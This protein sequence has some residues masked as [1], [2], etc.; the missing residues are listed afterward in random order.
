MLCQWSRTRIRFPRFVVYAA[1][2]ASS[3]IA[4]GQA[5]ASPALSGPQVVPGVTGTPAQQPQN[6]QL[7]SRI[8]L[9]IGPGDE[10]DIS[11]YGVP[12]MSQHERVNS[13]G[14]ISLPLVNYVHVAGLSSEEAEVLI[15]KRLIDGQFMKQPHVNIYVKEYTNIGIS[16]LGQVSKP[17]IYPITGSRRLWDM[18]LAAGGTTEKAGNIVSIT[19]RNPSVPAT[20]VTLSNDPSQSTRSNVE[21]LPGDTIV[22]SKAGIVY[23]LGEVNQAAGYVMENGQSV[24]VIQALALAHGPTRDAKLNGTKVIR[25]TSDG[26]KQIDVNLKDILQAKKKDLALF[27]GDILFVPGRR[28]RYAS[29]QTFSTILTIATGVALRTF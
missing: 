29:S 15:E 8:I 9:P 2:I 1:V 22:V 27:P 23:V 28:G 7:P 20:A 11:V 3:L 16:V 12:E 10:L 21:L 6:P 18:I 4:V 17:G 5:I 13:L 14:D 25:T 26:A 24:S 19:H